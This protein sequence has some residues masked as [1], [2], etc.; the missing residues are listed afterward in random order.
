M[1]SLF[2][3][4]A[5]ILVV[6]LG[7]LAWAASGRGDGSAILE[8]PPEKVPEL[9]DAALGYASAGELGVVTWNIGYGRGAAGDLSGPWPREHIERHL[10]GIAELIRSL[11]VDIAA[12]Q[13]V[14]LGAQRSHDIHEALYI[15]KRLGWPY[16]ACVTTWQAN[17][18]PFPY[19]PLSKQYGQMKSGQCVLSRFPIKKNVRYRLQQPESNPFYYNTFYLHRAIQHVTVGM[20]DKEVEVFNVHLEAYDQATREQHAKMVAAIVGDKGKELTILLGDMNAPPPGAPQLNGFVDEPEVDF[21]TDK[22]IQII[23]G[24]SGL[25]EALAGR[26]H[27]ETFTFPADKATRRLDYLY[28]GA[29]FKLKSGRIVTEAGSLSD[30][31]PVVAR[32]QR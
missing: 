15:A 25:T 5:T 2:T 30:H 27:P 28:A 10:D 13:E 7:Y 18:I 1:A 19:W 20:P 24:I 29:K 17:Y 6:V 3:L 12:L 16:F 32:L 31:L 9:P 4:V 11:N 8:T 22:T 21:S 14:D 23:D 26:G